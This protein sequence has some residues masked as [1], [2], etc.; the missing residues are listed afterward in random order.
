MS[1]IN[2]DLNSYNQ[3]LTVNAENKLL[4]G[5]IFTPFSLIE[6]M[7]DLI[8]NHLFYDKNLKWLDPGAGTGYFSIYLY[9]KLFE[10]LKD[11]IP[12]D[13]EKQSHHKIH[14]LYG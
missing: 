1:I 14:D 9:F 8:P 7:F 4:Y 12:N 11:N 10:T 5:E 13:M 2:L 6:K 3:N